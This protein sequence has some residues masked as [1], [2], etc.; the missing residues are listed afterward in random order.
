MI[1]QLGLKSCVA[2][3]VASHCNEHHCSAWLQSTEELYR[4]IS[5][6]YVWP[7]LV[8]LMVCLTN[9]SIEFVNID[10]KTLVSLLFSFFWFE[11]ISGFSEAFKVWFFVMFLGNCNFFFTTNVKYLNVQFLNV[12]A[13]IRKFSVVSLFES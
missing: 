12:S 11:L 13:D 8:I 5:F 6:C 1:V 3:K 4:W 9:Y 10:M 2:N 7:A